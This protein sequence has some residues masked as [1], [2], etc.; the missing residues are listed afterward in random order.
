MALKKMNMEPGKKYRGYALLNEYGEFDFVP[1]QTG[2]RAGLIKVVK[3]GDGFSVKESKKLVIIN[4][5]IEK[6]TKMEMLNNLLR[7][8]NTLITE[9]QNY[10]F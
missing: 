2:T 8:T 5:S 4:F 7:I 6:G 1:E 9:I 3:E 10:D